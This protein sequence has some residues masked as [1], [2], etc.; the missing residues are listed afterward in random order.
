MT[1]G[2]TGMSEVRT[3]PSATLDLTIPYRV[4]SRTRSVGQAGQV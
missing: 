1:S 4:A 2:I 3:A